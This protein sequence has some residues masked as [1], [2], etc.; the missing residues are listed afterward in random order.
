MRV[1]PHLT[2]DGQ[3]KSAFLAYQ[4]ILGGDVLTMLTY[5]ES[6]MASTVDKQWHDQIVHAAL[7]LGDI[8][9]TGAD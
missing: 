1:S 5:G 4:R 9:L 7:T 3:C 6:P 2:F 8:E